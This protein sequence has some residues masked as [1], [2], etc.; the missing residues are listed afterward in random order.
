MTDE[1]S[2]NH[3][4][5]A[6]FAGGCFWCMVSPFQN[7]SGVKKVLA[8]YTGG[9]TENPTYE[10]VCSDKTG[11]YEAVQITYNPQQCTYQK[12][13]DTFWKQIDP[14]DAGGQFNDRGQSYK[15][16]IFYH[17]KEQQE[18]AEKA[19]KVLSETGKFE[20]PVMTEILPASLFYP[21]EEYHQ[22]YHKKN[23]LHYFAYRKGSGR[24]DFIDKH[25]K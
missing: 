18:K 16:A 2:D 21:A 3:Q 17:N 14:T 20:Q 8:G 5:L 15:T 1:L 19:K 4:Q 11:H 10:E 22:D 12:L 13:L 25:W 7:L 9:C 24:E 23:P 6:T